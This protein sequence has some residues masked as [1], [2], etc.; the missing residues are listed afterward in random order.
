M[1]K[2]LII[3]ASPRKNGNSDILAQQFAKG[4]QEAGNDVETFYL[5][6]HHL[7]YCIGC[8]SCLKTGKCFQKDDANILGE[9]MM[10]AD[11]VVMA[12]PVYYYSLSGQM[13][14]FLDRM[15]PLYERMKDKDFYYI[16]TAAD[17]AHKQLDR[18]FDAFDGFADCFEDIRR[19]G[20]IY[21]GGADKKGYIETLTAY[22][23]AYEMGKNIK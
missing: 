19:C 16:L 23:E 8:L 2:V 4:A 22:T 12:S 18:A 21:G 14:V 5:R 10:A 11:V 9:K 13:K 6:E 3:A 7:D 20:R 1:K 17:D 15:N